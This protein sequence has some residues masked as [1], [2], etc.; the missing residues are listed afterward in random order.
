MSKTI[1]DRL[2]LKKIH[3]LYYNTFIEYD[4]NNPSRST[5]NFVPI[6]CDKIA[7]ELDIDPEIIFGRLYYHLDK[8]HS[9]TQGDGCKVTFFTKKSNQEMHLI[10]FP[11]LSAVL[12]E[13]EQFFYRAM[14]PIVIS[15][16]AI[17][18]SLTSLY[19]SK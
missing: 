17:T 1:T 9:Y 4:S 12:A 7:N 3:D 18:L 13:H 8:K 2:I 15:I 5:K 16:V 10:H 14:I 6:D 19:F 11:L